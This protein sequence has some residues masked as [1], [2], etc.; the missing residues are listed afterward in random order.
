MIGATSRRFAIAYLAKTASYHAPVIVGATFLSRTRT[1]FGHMMARGD[2]SSGWSWKDRAL[3]PLSCLRSPR[4]SRHRHPYF[5]LPPVCPCDDDHIP[6]LPTDRGLRLS[7]PGAFTLWG[8]GVSLSDEP[9]S[10]PRCPFLRPPV[11][12]S[13]GRLPVSQTSSRALCDLPRTSSGASP[14]PRSPWCS[15][16]PV[17]SSD[18]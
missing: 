1:M 15:A 6:W 18:Q 16:R 14:V 17:C 12:F 13:A 11:F 8:L 3:W 10:C 5:S 2:D 7:P 4:T 9:S